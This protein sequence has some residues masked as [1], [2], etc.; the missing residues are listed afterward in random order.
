MNNVFLG[1]VFWSQNGYH[2][3]EDVKIMIIIQGRFSQIW[4]QTN[5]KQIL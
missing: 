5:M 1:V 3:Y 4:L 2:G